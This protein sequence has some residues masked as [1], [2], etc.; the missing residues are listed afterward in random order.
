M[1]FLGGFGEEIGLISPDLLSRLIKEQAPPSVA[2]Y[3]DNSGADDADVQSLRIDFQSKRCSP[4]YSPQDPK[5]LI[6]VCPHTGILRIDYLW[7]FKNLKKLQLDNNL[8][9][10]IENLDSLVHLEWL[11]MC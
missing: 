8:I 2:I 7:P 11:G 10:K 6:Q 4:H 9:E 1:S 5:S 3:G